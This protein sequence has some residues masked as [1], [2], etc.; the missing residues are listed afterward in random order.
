MQNVTAVE[1]RAIS[2][3]TAPQVMVCAKIH[4]N[5]TSVARLDTCRKTALMEEA[6]NNNLNAIHV[7]DWAI[8]PETVLKRRNK[9]RPEAALEVLTTLGVAEQTTVASTVARVVTILVNARTSELKAV[10]VV[11]EVVET[12]ESRH[13][14]SV[15]SR[16]TLPATVM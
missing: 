7:E 4:D 1:R 13:A 14:T 12:I 15:T 10:V 8:S 9:S 2:P 11:V 16:A 6:P 5:V 3:R